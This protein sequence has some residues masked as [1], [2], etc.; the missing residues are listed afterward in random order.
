MVSYAWGGKDDYPI[1]IIVTDESIYMIG[2]FMSS[3]DF[4]PGSDID[5]HDSV[6]NM[7]AFLC[8]F[9]SDGSYEWTRTWG[10]INMI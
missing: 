3:V 10:V 4:D 1:R 2:S 6:G 9:R 5:K 7:D 8:K